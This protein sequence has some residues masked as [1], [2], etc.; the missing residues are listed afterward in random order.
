MIDVLVYLFE[1]YYN[2]AGYP[3]RDTLSK[4]LSRAGFDADDITDALEWLGGLTD[5]E[6]SSFPLAFKEGD[7][8]RSYSVSEFTKL[9]PDARGFLA[10]LD[11]ARV[12]TPTLRELI[13]ERAMAIRHDAV[14]LDQLKIIV[15]MVMW[16]QCGNIDALVLQ[17]L[18]PDGEPRVVH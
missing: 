11:S 2:G 15:L 5:Q 8:F 6:E 13:I 18:L 4:K 12:L 10:F 16:T 9:T 17:E 14:N 1:E 7:S 3:D